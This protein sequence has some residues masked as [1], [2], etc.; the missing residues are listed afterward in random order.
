MAVMCAKITNHTPGQYHIPIVSSSNNEEGISCIQCTFINAFGA[1]TCSMCFAA[2][3]RKQKTVHKPDVEESTDKKIKS[4]TSDTSEA[5]AD[6]VATDASSKPTPTTT[7][8]V[9]TKKAW[10]GWGKP[11]KPVKVEV[12]THT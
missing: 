1:K 5:N 6:S 12:F 10:G 3:P 4:T 9:P 11:S 7:T 8:K 2:L